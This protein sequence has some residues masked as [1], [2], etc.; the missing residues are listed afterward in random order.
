MNRI[1]SFFKKFRLGQI[2]TIF[3]AGL[4]LF[5]TTA[6]NS[7]DIR[8]ARPENPP[9][10]MGGQNNPY[11][12]GGDSY[13]QYKTS[14]DPNV[15]RPGTDSQPHAGLPVAIE[16]LIASSNIE[17]N[18]SDMLYP[19]SDATST[20]NPD[21]G[22]RGQQDFAR[23]A[24]QIPAQRQPIVDRSDPNTKILEKTGQAF[25]DASEFIQDTFEDVQE[26]PA[27]RQQLNPAFGK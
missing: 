15:Q 23:Q 24:K 26:N 20:A 14:P 2:L 5:L 12:R 19:G 27:P 21:I 22:P 25:K 16:Q 3:I 1:L 8:G 18:A 17:S 7:G 4:A 13:T 10:Q 9:V 11:K 6:C